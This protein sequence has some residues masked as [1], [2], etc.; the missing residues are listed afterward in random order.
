LELPSGHA[1]AATSLA[2]VFESLRVG[3]TL[4]DGMAWRNHENGAPL[5]VTP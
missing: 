4:W 3:A 2:H 5:R 1:L